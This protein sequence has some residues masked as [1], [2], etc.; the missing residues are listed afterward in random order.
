VPQQ[1]RKLG[2]NNAGCTFIVSTNDGN[3]VTQDVLRDI[4]VEQF[5]KKHGKQ[6]MV[7]SCWITF[8]NFCKTK[9]E[10]RYPC[11]FVGYENKPISLIP[12]RVD[13]SLEIQSTMSEAADFLKENNVINAG[14]NIPEPENKEA[15]DVAD[16]D[17]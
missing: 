9:K 14:I 17:M 10:I 3:K 1:D 6:F 15:F 16:V 12:L 11:I 4:D 2:C 13:S 8:E 5:I 7:L